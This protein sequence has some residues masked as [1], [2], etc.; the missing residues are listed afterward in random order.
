MCSRHFTR[1]TPEAHLCRASCFFSSHMAAAV[2][3]D[4][5]KRRHYDITLLISLA[6]IHF[7]TALLCRACHYATSTILLDGRDTRAIFIAGELSPV[8]QRFPASAT[9]QRAYAI[10]HHG[11]KMRLRFFGAVSFAAFACLACAAEAF[12]AAHNDMGVTFNMTAWVANTPRLMYDFISGGHLMRS[13]FPSRATTATFS[14]F[15]HNEFERLHTTHIINYIP[16]ATCYAIEGRRLID[17]DT[18][19]YYKFKILISLH[20]YGALY[21][22]RAALHT[23]IRNDDADWRNIATLL[24]SLHKIAYALHRLH[25]TLKQY[26]PPLRHV[27]PFFGG[28]YAFIYTYILA[29][30]RAIRWHFIIISLFAMMTFP[31]TYF[32]TPR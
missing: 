15:Y 24:N 23:R 4:A 32:H 2:F 28:P 17:F 18:W 5:G 27:L 30:I 21:M 22:P 9:L 25:L 11:A 3:S 31:A 20:E 1:H 26:A 10:L 7:D 6:S 8:I 12:Y 19:A 14:C 16:S 13:A 29:I